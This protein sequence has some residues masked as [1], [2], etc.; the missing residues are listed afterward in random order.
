MTDNELQSIN[1]ALT[2]N[3]ANL[4]KM[5]FLGIVLLFVYGVIGYIWF[6]DDY[7]TDLSYSSTFL[8]TV[9][10]TI[11]DGLRFYKNYIE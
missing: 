7:N 2:M 10:T 5:S 9:F 8:V 3:S 6:T 4:L 1:Q 11:K